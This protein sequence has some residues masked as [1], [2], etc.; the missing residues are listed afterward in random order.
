[1]SCSENGLEASW[2]L[3]LNLPLGSHVDLEVDSLGLIYM[4]IKSEFILLYHFFGHACS[5]WKFPG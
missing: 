1:M 5:M 2:N 3:F 4:S